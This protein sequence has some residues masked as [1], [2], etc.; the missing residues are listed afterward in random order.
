MK[1]LVSVLKSIFT[2]FSA[3]AFLLLGLLACF[4]SA[5]IE[6]FV[7]KELLEVP[8]LGIDAMSW[9]ALIVL[10]L[11]GSKFTLHFYAEVL[12]RKGLDEEIDDMDIKKKR[13]LIVAVKNS[14]VALSLVC[15]II[16]M[17]NIM[18][19][20]NV[21]RIDAYIQENEEYCDRK[22]EEEIEK[23]EERKQKRIE[24]LTAIYDSE[25][26]SIGEMQEVL[27]T[28]LDAITSEDF[29]NRR[30]DLQEEANATRTQIDRMEEVYQ[31]HVSEAQRIAEDEYKTQL[32]AIQA[33]YGDGGSE[34]VDKTAPEVLMA[35]DNPYLSNFL[36]TLSKT[37]LGRGYSR[38]TYFLCTLLI[39]LII[40]VMLEL[41]ISI[42]QMLLAIKA[43]SFVKIIGDIPGAESGKR[44]VRLTLWLMF[45]VLIATAVFCIVSI[46][47]HMS[48]EGERIITALITYLIAILLIN[49]VAPKVEEG[50]GR[51]DASSGIGQKATQLMKGLGKVVLEV[52]IPGAITFV[53]YL[54]V[55][56]IFRGEFVYGDMTG[57]AIA[58]GG[59]CSRAIRFDQCDFA[60]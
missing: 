60:I 45:S 2:P 47:L 21:E 23:I 56:F 12:K 48:I 25:R 14:L 35:G 6:M 34:R 11:E 17:T 33:K 57:L 27:G 52:A 46:M 10:V 9:A 3:F 15:S 13:K 39:S 4:C 38:I 53:G 24:E 31:G 19:N 49:A 26:E 32:K 8:G 55:G 37:F 5:M 43:D 44:V 22:L 40:S 42:S 30:Q 1:A 51:A 16:C 54:L 29:I 59:I 41:C 36:N 50:G 58:I 28:L 20:D 7:L 18:Y